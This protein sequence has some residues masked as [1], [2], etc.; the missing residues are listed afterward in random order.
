MIE[1]IGLHGRPLLT[2]ADV[3][4]FAVAATGGFLVFALWAGGSI[5][6]GMVIRA[7]FTTYNTADDDWQPVRNFIATHLFGVAIIVLSVVFVWAIMSII[8]FFEYIGVR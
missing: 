1:S 3:V 5:V 6:A 4:E 8:F 2:V 7:E